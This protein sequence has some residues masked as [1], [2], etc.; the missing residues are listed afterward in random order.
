MKLFEFYNFPDNGRD[1]QITILDYVTKYL[2]VERAM[3]ALKNEVLSRIIKA[4]KV[5]HPTMSKSLH[6]L[7]KLKGSDNRFTLLMC[8]AKLMIHDIGPVLQR[9]I[10]K[11]IDLAFAKISVQ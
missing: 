9:F 7:K 8:S 3:D 6:I 11:V 4:Y 2:T 10:E 1:S 5:H